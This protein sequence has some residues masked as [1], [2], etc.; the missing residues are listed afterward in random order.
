MRNWQ[1]LKRD[2]IDPP[3]LPG[4]GCGMRL[5]HSSRSMNWRVPVALW[6]ARKHS[7]K[8]FILRKRDPFGAP[9]LS[10]SALRSHL[11]LHRC[12][13]DMCD[14]NDICESLDRSKHRAG[15]PAQISPAEKVD[16][17]IGS[18][19]FSFLI[20]SDRFGGEKCSKNTIWSINQLTN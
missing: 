8:E 11:L 17:S 9:S 20:I 19:C 7:L 4:T 6:Q 16:L 2:G 13:I 10:G 14:F 3:Q 5:L 15:D 12:G 1:R 18:M